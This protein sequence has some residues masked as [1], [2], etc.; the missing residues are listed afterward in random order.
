MKINPSLATRPLII[1][2][3]LRFLRLR[4]F[5]DLHFA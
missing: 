4:E 2:F 1:Q 5:F 3:S